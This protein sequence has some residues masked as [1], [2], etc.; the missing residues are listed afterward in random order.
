MRLA[1]GVG[2]SPI[3]VTALFSPCSVHFRLNPRPQTSPSALNYSWPPPQ[4]FS[5]SKTNQTR[6]KK[7]FPP[8]NIGKNLKEF[9]EEEKS[10]GCI[11]G[12]GSM[13]RID[14]ATVA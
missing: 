2:G 1:A 6:N 8:L 5:E 11:G 3:A 12:V 10:D 9:E 13:W 7:P 4:P 14:G